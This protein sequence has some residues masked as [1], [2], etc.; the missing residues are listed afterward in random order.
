MFRSVN[1][2]GIF[3]FIPCREICVIQHGIEV[4]VA[5]VKFHF[6]TSKGCFGYISVLPLI[7]PER[8]NLK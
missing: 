1:Q 5:P 6:P 7:I 4:A 2:I 3:S 8:G